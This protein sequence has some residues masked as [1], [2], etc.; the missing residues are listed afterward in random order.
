MIVRDAKLLKLFRQKPYC[1]YCGRP[2]VVQPHHVFARGM[3]GGNRLDIS[4]NLIA[5]CPTGCHRLFH[6][7]KIEREAFLKVIA[8]RERLTVEAIEDAIY[9]L[10]RTPRP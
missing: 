2:G 7:G 4:I 1:E 6:D 5:L 8:R 9:T 3:S 10:L